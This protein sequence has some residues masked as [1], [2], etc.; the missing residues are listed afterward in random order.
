ML[1]MMA[2]ASIRTFVIVIINISLTTLQVI[3]SLLKFCCLFLKDEYNSSHGGKWT[4]HNLRVY[5][6]GTRGK[7][8]FKFYFYPA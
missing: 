4:V 6:E 8:V 1:Y 5:L 7:E 2:Y 3:N